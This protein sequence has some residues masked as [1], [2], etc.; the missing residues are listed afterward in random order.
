MA[1]N[2]TVVNKAFEKALRSSAFDWVE[3]QGLH[4]FVLMPY[5]VVVIA[6]HKIDALAL[7][8]LVATLIRNEFENN[9]FVQAKI[10]EQ[11]QMLVII[12]EKGRYSPSNK[13]ASRTPSTSSYISD[14]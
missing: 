13:E 1:V 9:S 6:T 14:G 8:A 2:H 3:E 11:Y 12:V 10:E 7:I 4:K 5:V